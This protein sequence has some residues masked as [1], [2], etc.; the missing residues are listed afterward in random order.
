MGVPKSP[1]G[2]IQE[3]RVAKP[4]TKAPMVRRGENRLTDAD[5]RNAKPRRT[6]Y[7]LADGRGMYLL[8][9]PHGARLCRLK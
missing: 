1:I 6:A 4:D 7:K 2:G 5:C 9:Q 8:V 3:P